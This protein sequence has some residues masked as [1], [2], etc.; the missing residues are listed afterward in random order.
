MLGLW[1]FKGQVE[2]KLNFKAPSHKLWW[3]L[4]EP[5]HEIMV[6]PSTFQD[7][8]ATA[9]K[10]KIEIGFSYMGQ[11]NVRAL[12]FVYNIGCNWYQLI[13]ETTK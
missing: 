13:I 10:I 7:S 6:S 4:K 11:L 8:S 2:K 5:R 12:R 1:K 3:S 9:N